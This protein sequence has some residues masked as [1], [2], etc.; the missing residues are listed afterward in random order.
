MQTI[1]TFQNE[2]PVFLR[3]QANHMYS[4]S[5]YYFAKIL[6]ETPIFSIVPMLF[7]VIFYFKTGFT[8]AAS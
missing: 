1:L 4:V 5:S 2:R 6:V 8:I 7:A 3:E